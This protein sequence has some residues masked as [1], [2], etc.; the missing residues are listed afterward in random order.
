MIFTAG[1]HI[2]ATQL[3]A[4]VWLNVTSLSRGVSNS[5]GTSAFHISCP[6]FTQK[7]GNEASRY[8]RPDWLVV[9]SHERACV[10][11]HWAA[12]AHCLLSA[13]VEESQGGS[14]PFAGTQLQ[15]CGEI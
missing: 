9:S 14:D 3:Y 7:S 2:V 6:N 5:P 8:L 12:K 1:T 13:C 11:A 4:G 15:S 10:I